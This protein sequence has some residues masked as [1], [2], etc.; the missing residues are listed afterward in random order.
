VSLKRGWRERG[1]YIL[2][3]FL[4]WDMVREE[5]MGKEGRRRWWMEVAK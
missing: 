4:G 3:A 2:T 5:R 1:I